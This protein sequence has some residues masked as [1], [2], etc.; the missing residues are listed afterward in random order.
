MV[1]VSLDPCK[2]ELSDIQG[3]CSPSGLKKMKSEHLTFR[4]DTI[5][6]GLH[7]HYIRNREEIPNPRP[8]C[9]PVKIHIQHMLTRHNIKQQGHTATF[10]AR[11]FDTA[12]FNIWS[13]VCMIAHSHNAVLT[14][15][16]EH[17]IL[18]STRSLVLT[19]SRPILPA[20]ATGRG[21]FIGFIVTIAA[22]LLAPI[23]VV[24]FPIGMLFF[25][26]T[27]VSITDQWG[28]HDARRLPC[29]WG[30]DPDLYAYRSRLC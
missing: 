22:V 7:R 9:E 12:K 15:R 16:N 26:A 29:S 30:F 18:H 6:R 20:T 27:F 11:P 1:I 21:F 3:I 5:A 14:M 23:D 8:V 4:K 24:P 25:R 17:C 2:G 28:G 10:E 13:P 19:P